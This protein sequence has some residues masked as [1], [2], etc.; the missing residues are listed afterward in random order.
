MFR[1]L[2]KHIPLRRLFYYPDE[3]LLKFIQL[4]CSKCSFNEEHSDYDEEH[5]DYEFGFSVTLIMGRIGGTSLEVTGEIIY[6]LQINT[7]VSIF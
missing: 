3:I 5:S 1:S 2:G 4:F 6:L 7:F